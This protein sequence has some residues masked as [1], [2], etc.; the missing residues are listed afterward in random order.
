MAGTRESTYGR[1]ARAVGVGAMASHLCVLQPAC[2][3]HN[4]QEQA[5]HSPWTSKRHMNTQMIDSGNPSPIVKVK[6][7][8]HNTQPTR[9]W[10]QDSQSV[11]ISNYR[12]S[13]STRHCSHQCIRSTLTGACKLGLENMA[14]TQVC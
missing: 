8:R 12:V 11:R 4:E 9:I 3:F 2:L 14:Q 6:E 7:E 13:L 5:N 1:A 10:T